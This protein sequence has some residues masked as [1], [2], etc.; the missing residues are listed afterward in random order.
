MYD[1]SGLNG[2]YSVREGLAISLQSKRNM[3]QVTIS[4][5]RRK[6]HVF[7]YYCETLREEKK[8]ALTIVGASFF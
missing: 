1:I 4:A 3:A 8:V 5:C 7:N 6:S 2:D